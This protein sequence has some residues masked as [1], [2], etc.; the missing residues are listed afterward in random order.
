MAGS[1]TRSSRGSPHC[2]ATSRNLR[3]RL[4]AMLG[5]SRVLASLLASV[6]IISPVLAQPK[7]KGAQELVKKAITASNRGDH[8]AAI[9]LYLEA[10]KMAPVPVLLSNIGREYQQADKQVEALKYFCK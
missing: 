1:T 3:D 8:L 10:Y 4:Y 6:M 7:D 9:D 2:L 5:P